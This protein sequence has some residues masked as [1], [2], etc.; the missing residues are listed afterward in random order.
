M[1]NK[2]KVYKA[3][4]EAINT[5]V[6]ASVKKAMMKLAIKDGRSLSNYCTQL[7]IRSIEEAKTNG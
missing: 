6:P 2:V 4:G 1:I 3:K 5:R 7:F